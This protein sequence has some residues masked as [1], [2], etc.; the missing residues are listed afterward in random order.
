MKLISIYKYTITPTLW[1]AGGWI[2]RQYA[3][4]RAPPDRLLDGRFN[5][6]SKNET[7]SEAYRQELFFKSAGGKIYLRNK[8]II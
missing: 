2:R 1:E 8:G 3:A 4:V 7:K 5:V 6:S